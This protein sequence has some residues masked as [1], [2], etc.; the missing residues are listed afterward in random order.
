[1][2]SVRKEHNWNL[3]QKS[4]LPKGL[5]TW[6]PVLVDWS[7][8]CGVSTDR[9]VQL[10]WITIVSKWTGVDGMELLQTYDFNVLRNSIRIV[11][12]AV[13]LGLQLLTKFAS[14]HYLVQLL[15]RLVVLW[16][17]H[18]G[19]TSSR[20]KASQTKWKT[21]KETNNSTSSRF[22]H[23]KPMLC[24]WVAILSIVSN[25]VKTSKKSNVVHYYLFL[26][27]FN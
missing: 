16:D 8:H 18:V 2:Q 7:S 10:F 15:R 1:M 12:D 11:H 25:R 9:W 3:S 22:L 5:P 27:L 17:L 6:L 20:D 4:I 19:P 21:P 13:E 24:W 14:P 23:N 26:N